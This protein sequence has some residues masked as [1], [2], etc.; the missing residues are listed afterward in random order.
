MNLLTLRTAV[1]G[2]RPAVDLSLL[3]PPGPGSIDDAKVASRQIWTDGGWRETPVYE[4]FELPASAVLEGP[5]LLQ[6]PDTTILIE[7]GMRARTD[8]LG[9]VFVEVAAR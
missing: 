6:Q 2:H 5:C 9:N 4:R 8:A 7:P 3:A 1:I